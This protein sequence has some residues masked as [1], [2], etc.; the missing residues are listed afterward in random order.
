MEHFVFLL[1]LICWF[2]PL[3]LTYQ[4]I[5]T[6]NSSLKINVQRNKPPLIALADENI[7]PSFKA[8]EMEPYLSQREPF[9]L[10]RNSRA[11]TL[12][13]SEN[14]IRIK[15]P[16]LITSNIIKIKPAE[17]KSF[18]KKPLKTLH[19]KGITLSSLENIQSS[20]DQKPKDYAIISQDYKEKTEQVI[21]SVIK[22]T[23]VIITDELSDFEKRWLTYM[24]GVEEE[25]KN[26]AFSTVMS[27][28]NEQD[29]SV[30]IGS[31]MPQQKWVNGI[32]VS[33]S[34][35]KPSANLGSLVISQEAKNTLEKPTYRTTKS[36]EFLFEYT[37][38]ISANSMIS[39]DP[40]D[41]IDEDDRLEK[42]MNLPPM[43]VL[44]DITL[45]NGL[46]LLEGDK[47]SVAYVNSCSIKHEADV[48]LR[49]GRFSIDIEDPSFGFLTAQ[50][51]GKDG[52]L[53]GSGR[54]SLRRFF[55]ENFMTESNFVN[56]AEID[57]QVVPFDHSSTLQFFNAGVNREAL[58]DSSVEI[59]DIGR[60]VTS[61]KNGLVS[62]P[63]ILAD[64]SFI[65]RVDKGGLW[66]T[67]FLSTNDVVYEG[68]IPN[69][70]IIASLQRDISNLNLNLGV[71]WGRV[72]KD[73]NPIEGV[74]L[75]LA[76]SQLRPY[77]LTENQFIEGDT[78]TSTGYFAYVNVP[79]G[80]QLL[81]GYSERF[82]VLSR[83]LWTDSGY[84]S[85]VKL[86][87]TSG[88]E[89]EGCIFDSQTGNLL[90]ARINYLGSDIEE[91]VDI[92]S[93]RLGLNF[94]N[95]ADPLY[96]ELRPNEQGYHPIILTSHRNK[97]AISFPVPSRAWINELAARHK[98]TQHPSLS[99]IVG[100]ISNS[101]FK[102]YKEN[103]ND[104]TE[105]VYFNREESSQEPL[106]DLEQGGFV[107]FNV[108]TGLQSIV[109]EPQNSIRKAAIKTVIADS[110]FASVFSH[111]F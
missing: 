74:S 96:F 39:M 54:I 81:K 88:K 69:E 24:E 77:Y 98:I 51:R 99:M 27:S 93:G 67:L 89:A 55:E 65:T 84:V 75:E 20:D 1:F 60:V 25:K 102:V 13:S 57:L 36:K 40:L 85:S 92:Q 108:D 101:S 42:L 83:F 73:G 87:E 64:S 91:E 70:D 80:I 49:N 6:M 104:H 30:D 110:D 45:L 43:R 103:V 79:P 26:K 3:T 72:L 68:E 21:D 111:K 56:T 66:K 5:K 17:I 95:S 44:G 61:S 18:K 109:L 22:P 16:L 38:S 11:I 9:V 34:D 7:S 41:K 35:Q 71:I 8:I 12:S 107:L 37:D 29:I 48:D 47:L 63:E 82:A 15:K 52:L 23:E 19:L 53:R 46:G 59:K 97:E 33:R 86:E 58:K 32:W 50:L 28:L 31:S 105:I 106:P 76:E 62:F 78:T 14:I 2:F 90:S 4:N 100:Y 94:F 10:A